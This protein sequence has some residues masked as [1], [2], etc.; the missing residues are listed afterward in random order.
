MDEPSFQYKRNQNGDV[1]R[2]FIC[3]CATILY[4]KNLTTNVIEFLA[5]PQGGQRRYQYIKPGGNPSTVTI[6]CPDCDMEHIVVGVME[7]IPVDDDI[8]SSTEVL[9]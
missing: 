2:P 4:K 6:T 1:I 9:E 7:T 5:F 8:A 3:E